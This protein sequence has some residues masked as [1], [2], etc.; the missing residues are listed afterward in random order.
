[1][2]LQRR[3]VHE[4]GKHCLHPPL[5]TQIPHLLRA[6]GLDCSAA[7]EFIAIPNTEWDDAGFGKEAASNA[8]KH[9]AE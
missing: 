4:F 5:P 9:V 1:M 2:K 8:V 3:I 6:A 7:S